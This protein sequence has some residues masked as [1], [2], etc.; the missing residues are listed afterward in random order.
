MLKRILSALVLIP[1]VTAA[2]FLAPPLVFALVIALLGTINLHELLQMKE[3]SSPSTARWMT[4]TGGLVAGCLVS[5]P[6]CPEFR[7]LGVV[8]FFLYQACLSVFFSRKAEEILDWV[9]LP[10]AGFVY[11]YVFFSF[12]YEMRF[13]LV[14]G[15]GAWLL[16][17]FLAIQWVGD[18]FAFLAGSTLGRHK[19]RPLLSPKKS[20]E[21]AAGGLLGSAVVGA[22]MSLAVFPDRPWWPFALVGFAMGAFGQIG[23]LLESQFKRA[24]GVKDSSQLIPGH[25]GLLDRM[26]SLIL[27]APLFYLSMRWLT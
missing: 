2:V 15:R 6:I 1:L 9:V 12:V 18:T 19:L 13:A 26:D 24:F 3:G 27:T 25:G 8:L 7:S 23:D 10:V 4:L 5:Y 20:V 22:V 11:I 17:F 14:P 16:I 21:G